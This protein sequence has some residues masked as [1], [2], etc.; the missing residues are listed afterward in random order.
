LSVAVGGCRPSDAALLGGSWDDLS[1]YEANLIQSEETSLESLQ[2]A[3]VYHLDLTIASDFRTVTGRE[4]V[5]YTNRETVDLA[6]LYF[7]LF[8]NTSG[9]RTTVSA[10][11][12][13]KKRVNF[14]NAP[15][16]SALKVTLRQPL[17]PG[18]AVTVQL[19]F[20]VELP[21]STADNSGLFGYFSDV[22]A[23]DCLYPVIPVYDE[24]GWQIGPSPQ[25]GDKTYLD[26]AFYLARVK[27]PANM[28]LI[29]S[30]VEVSREATREDQIITFA[31]G[32][33]RDFYL[34][35]SNR[36]T[37]LSA[38]LGE[39]TINS[40][41]LP[42]QLD[43]AQLALSVAEDAI[44]VYGNR[45]GVYPYTEL[46][47]V[48]LALQGGGIGIEYP[49]VFGIAIAI[50]GINSVLETTVAHEMGHQWFYNV[51]GDDQVNQPWL[52]ESMTQY[53]TGLYFLDTYGQAGW[54]RSRQAW[55]NFWGRTSQ[56]RIPIGL[57][58]D[59]YLGNTYGPIV[60]GRGPLFVAA[61]A[62][63][64]GQAAF[65]NCLR[66]YYQNHKWQIV[67]T[68]VYRDWF[69]RCSGKDLD[70][71]FKEWVLP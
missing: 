26:A 39:T 55:L 31:A 56:A 17:K 5:R 18:A 14:E 44:K 71:I 69:E 63:S 68:A 43:G 45:L 6:V 70:A 12:V 57:P 50:Y 53:I 13:D 51:V 7:Q 67:T 42:G 9:G 65:D 40:Y 60:Y 24:A 35:G 36:F 21:R 61:L 20:A 38:T 34:A 11:K 30:G 54:E 66:Q 2:E 19:D 48:P 22:L 8:P 46:D 41:Y 10:V 3:S 29:A 32:P 59:D 33:A 16:A 62:E 28:T 27:A 52:D 37:K 25:D 64:I 1:I 15:G 4:Q 47:I 23:L 49:G 58:V